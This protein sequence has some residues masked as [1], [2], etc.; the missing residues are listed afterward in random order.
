MCATPATARTVE[1]LCK[2]LNDAL[3]SAGFL[4]GEPVVAT[5]KRA[6]GALVEKVAPPPLSDSDTERL[7]RIL[8]AA[9]R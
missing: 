8:E 7:C 9:R 6:S 4:D 5:L 3:K 2:R 1:E